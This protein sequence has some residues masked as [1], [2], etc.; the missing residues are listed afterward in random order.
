MAWKKWQ[1]KALTKEYTEKNKDKILQERRNA[2]LDEKIG[3]KGYLKNKA[4]G[5]ASKLGLANVAALGSLYFNA[6]KSNIVRDGKGGFKSMALAFMG[7]SNDYIERENIFA[8]IKKEQTART[9]AAEIEKA[10]LEKEKNNK[11]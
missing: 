9:Q 2:I 4:V 3:E 10:K 7:K 1:G 5:A 8:K 6:I 11:R